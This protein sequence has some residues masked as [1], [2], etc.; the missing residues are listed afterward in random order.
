VGVTS[1][2]ERLAERHGV[3]IEYTK[4]STPALNDAATEAGVGFAASL[5]G[6]FIV[7]GFLPA[8]DGAAALVKMLDLMAHHDVRLSKVVDEL[9][10]PHL[11]HETVVTPWDHKGAVMRNL[12][13]HS[14]RPTVLVDGVKV[15]HDDGWVLC[16]PDPEEAVTHVYAEATSDGEARRLAREYVLRIRQ[17][18]R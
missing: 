13:E 17:L 11:V 18:V 5:D 7:P 14:S 3:R 12:V 9:P 2:A 1:L 8:Y 6:G 4:M 10:R 16:L 15:I